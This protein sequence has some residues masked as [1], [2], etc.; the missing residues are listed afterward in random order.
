MGADMV[1][2]TLLDPDYPS[3]VLRQICLR[4]AD[5][6]GSDPRGLAAFYSEL[7]PNQSRLR[8]LKATFAMDGLIDAKRKSLYLEPVVKA[9]TGIPKPYTVN[10]I[11]VH[12]VQQA[13]AKYM[14]RQF[15]SEAVQVIGQSYEN[16]SS[17]E[18]TVYIKV[19]DPNQVSIPTHCYPPKSKPIAQSEA[20]D[21]QPWWK[22]FAVL[23]GALSIGVL[24]Y[25]SL[26]KFVF[27]S[28]KIAQ[29][30]V[31]LSGE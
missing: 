9:F 20:Q 11:H 29:T 27:G 17:I 10:C 1:E 22:F 3:S 31:G 15:N 14:V 2:I 19:Q 7:Q 4:L 18:Y 28:L 8:F 13:P 6:A 5:F 23:G 30:K 16:P 12:F 26:L 24:V 25:I 21:W